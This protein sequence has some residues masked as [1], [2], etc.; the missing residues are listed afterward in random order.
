VGW[1]R[2][3]NHQQAARFA[4]S[5][6]TPDMLGQQRIEMTG[7]PSGGAILQCLNLVERDDFRSGVQK[8]SL[9]V[10]CRFRAWATRGA[11]ILNARITAGS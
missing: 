10:M 5:P 1:I 7:Y 3:F 6:Q 9:T 2:D 8:Q 4:R 11:A